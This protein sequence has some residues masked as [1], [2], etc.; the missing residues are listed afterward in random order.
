LGMPRVSL[1]SRINSSSSGTPNTFCNIRSVSRPSTHTHTR[2]RVTLEA[3]LPRHD[4]PFV[5][6]AWRAAC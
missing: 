5:R 2:W 6:R 1:P 3:A 4:V